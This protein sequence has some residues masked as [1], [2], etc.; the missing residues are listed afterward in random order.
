M[1]KPIH[2]SPR[3]VEQELLLSMEKLEGMKLATK[4][5]TDAILDSIS[6]LTKAIA[7]LTK[8][9][10]KWYRAGKM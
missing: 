6:E 1:P 8:E 4:A 10:V 2:K 7:D 5:D 9:N 3:V